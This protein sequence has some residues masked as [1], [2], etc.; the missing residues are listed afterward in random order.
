MHLILRTLLLF[1]RSR[2]RSALSAWDTSSLPLRTLPTDIDLAG[3]VNNGMYFSLM[4]LGRFD[5]MVRAGLWGEMQ[6]RGW[7]P[8][9]QTE[10]ITFRKSLKLWTAYSL[11]TKWLGM[12]SHSMYFEQRFVVDDEIYAR[13]YVAGRLRGPNGPVSNDEIREALSQM[14]MFEPADRVV[15]DWMMDWRK[16]TALPSSRRRAPHEW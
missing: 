7:S 4:D 15:P 10:T 11:E 14:G 12:D 16:Q 3:I 5:L 1:I 13:A 6:R 2:R 8:V 9:V